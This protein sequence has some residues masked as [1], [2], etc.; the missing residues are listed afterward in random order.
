MMLGDRPRGRALLAIHQRGKDGRAQYR[1][2]TPEPRPD[3]LQPDYSILMP[4]AAAAAR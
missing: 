4:A 3:L 2:R 1:P